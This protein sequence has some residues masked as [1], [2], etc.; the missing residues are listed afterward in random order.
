MNNDGYRINGGI[1]FS[2]ESPN[3]YI[4]FEPS[5]SNNII[6]ERKHGFTFEELGRLKCHL[7]NV[8]K[9]KRF[10][11]G[12]NCV[13]HDSMIQSHV[14]F[15]SN[16]LIYLACVEALFILNGQEYNDDEII[17]ISGRG[18]TSGIGIN[19]YFRGGFVF[20][21]GIVNQGQR[22]IAPSSVFVDNKND[23]P[24]LL[25]ELRLPHWNLGV[26]IP[27]IEHKT[28]DEEKKF[29][30]KCC[31]IEKQS[32][33][34]ILYEAVYGITSSLMENDFR[35]FCKS[36]NAIQCTKWKFLERETYGEQLFNVERKIRD[37]G[38]ECVGMSSLGPMLYFFGRDIDVIIDIIK[39]EMP[40]CVC[41]KTAFNN[42]GRLVEND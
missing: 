42:M 35:V 23:R 22:N 14:G 11:L 16:T 18:G 29:F 31:P 41:F 25:K 24:L 7:D 21:T 17:A 20:D 36:I 6:D 40:Q 19:T 34:P 9:N 5:I 8:K 15:G 37:A 38:A 27:F 39:Q 12:A 32:V 1:G 13:V 26:C 33:E 30:Q 3:L 4:S 10:D 2:I 28:E